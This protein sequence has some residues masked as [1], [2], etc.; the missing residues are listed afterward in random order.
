MS[1]SSG[2]TALLNGIFSAKMVF[3]NRV[4]ASQVFAGLPYKSIRASR[5]W[6]PLWGGSGGWDCSFAVVHLPDDAA[7]TPPALSPFQGWYLKWGPGDWVATPDWAPCDNCR[8]AVAMCS[9]DLDAGM[10]ARLARAL[11]SPGSWAQDDGVGETVSVYSA[12]E[13]IAACI[14]FGD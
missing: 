14:R 10:A 12:P 3:Q 13:R 1:F 6:H 2:L 4:C 9:K 11:A 8:D 7:S 5:R